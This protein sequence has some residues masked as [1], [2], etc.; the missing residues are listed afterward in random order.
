M[1]TGAKCCRIL[2]IRCRHYSDVPLVRS[3]VRVARDRAQLAW[4]EMIWRPGSADSQLAILQLLGG[5]GIAVLIFFHRLR[6]DQVGDVNQHAIGVDPLAADLFFQRIEQLVDLNGKR[7]RLGLAFAVLG[8]FLAQLD[9]VF[10]ANR[11]RQL[12]FQ[13]CLAEGAVRTISLGAFRLCRAAGRRSGQRRGGWRAPP[14]EGLITVENGSETERKHRASAEADA[15]HPRVLQNCFVLEF[16]L[17]AS[18]VL[19]DYHGEFTAGIAQNRS[20]VHTLNA[21]QEERAPRA[22]SI[23][24][25][26]AQ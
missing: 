3:A 26:V 1:R 25:S 8:S 22:Y 20:C 9:Q 7:P 24:G 23:G 14:G 15:H 21:F 4:Q 13:Q 19:A 16:A 10:A 2:H 6:I 5:A 11:I 18:V 12:D 17:S